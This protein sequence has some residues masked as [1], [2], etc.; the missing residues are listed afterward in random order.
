MDPLGTTRLD[1]LLK[2]LE[3]SDS[4]VAM[5]TGLPPATV[6]RY[7]KGETSPRLGIAVMIA[8]ALGVRLADA[9]DFDDEIRRVQTSNQ[10]REGSGVWVVQ[11]GPGLPDV[12]RKLASSDTDRVR[13]D[14]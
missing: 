12:E 13:T 4:A 7:R 5:S 14:A 11:P 3:W 2:Q 8:R 10:S 9:F 1:A 6:Q